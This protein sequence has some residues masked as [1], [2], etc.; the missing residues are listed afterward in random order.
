[1]KIFCLNV[2]VVRIALFSAGMEPMLLSLCIEGRQSFKFCALV[3]VQGYCD[4]LTEEE[5]VQA[6]EIG[7]VI[8]FSL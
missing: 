5:L 4:F 3:C 8:P 6:V 2:S 1:M 7:H